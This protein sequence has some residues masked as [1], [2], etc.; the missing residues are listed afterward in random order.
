MGIAGNERAD[1]AA[2]LA[3]N[4]PVTECKIPHTDYKQR[5]NAYFVQ[6]WQN[7]W[8][9]IAFNKLQPIKSEIGETK[10]EGITRR[11]DE[12]ILHRARIGHSH[13]TH[14]YLLKGED[15]PEC[16]PC[17][18][19]FTVEHILVN[20]QDLA[21]TRQKY[22]TVSSLKELFNT[23]PNSQVLNFLQDIHLYNRF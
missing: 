21:L 16:I 1:T 10:L 19:P 6:A 12:L 20:C 4:L 23:V 18:C 22:Y 3:L 7:R 11:R 5:I 15:Q 13:L 14:C 9:N 8:N 17:Q 2:K